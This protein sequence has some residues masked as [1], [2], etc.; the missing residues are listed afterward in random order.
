MLY[1][2]DNFGTPAAES[3]CVPRR[4]ASEFHV[5]PEMQSD[6]AAETLEPIRF[7]HS[8]WPEPVQ[9]FG[10]KGLVGLASV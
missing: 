2:P 7:V 10:R 9:P 1:E 8:I 3:G 6:S 5:V 4:Q